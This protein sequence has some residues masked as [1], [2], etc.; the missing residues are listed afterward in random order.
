MPDKLIDCVHAQVPIITEPSPGI[1]QFVKKWS[2]GYVTDGFS[3]GS[4]RKLLSS[5]DVK[6]LRKMTSGVEYVTTH[7]NSATY[8]GRLMKVVNFV[9]SEESN[10]VLLIRVKSAFVNGHLKVLAGGQEKSSLWCVRYLSF[11]RFGR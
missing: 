1:A 6:E 5:I 2:I 10:Y 11:G 4:L 9:L 7:I 8:V 3:T